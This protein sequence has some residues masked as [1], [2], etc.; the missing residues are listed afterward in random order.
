[1]AKQCPRPQGGLIQE[2]MKEAEEDRETCR[3]HLTHFTPEVMNRQSETYRSVMRIKKVDEKH[4]LK[5]LIDEGSPIKMV[6]T[7]GTKH[8][9]ISRK[10]WMTWKK[11]QEWMT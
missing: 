6:I 1:M 7:K 9:K 2:A 4:E 10:E 8:L 3:P 11:I 5:D